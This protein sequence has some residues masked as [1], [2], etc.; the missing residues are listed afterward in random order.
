MS[1]SLPTQDGHRERKAH[2]GNDVVGMLN[3]AFRIRS[4]ARDMD[5]ENPEEENMDGFTTQ[6][7]MEH[8]NV[9]VQKLSKLF[10]DANR[11]LYLG[12]RKFTT[13]FF[14]LHLY[15]IKCTFG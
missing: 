3:D 14:I 10:K 5:A 4:E 13:L 12:C 7:T 6:D 1:M 15:H 11:E 9:E 2:E 8:F